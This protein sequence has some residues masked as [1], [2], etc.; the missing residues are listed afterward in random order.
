MGPRGLRMQDLLM[1]AVLTVL[2][3]GQVIMGW[4][5]TGPKGWKGVGWI[6]LGCGAFSAVFW[7]V[8]RT[9]GS[10]GVGA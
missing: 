7:I 1:I 4:H 8:V 2:I 5:G 9:L 6:F 3:F 10:W